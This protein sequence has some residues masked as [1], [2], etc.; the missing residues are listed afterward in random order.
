MSLAAEAVI[1]RKEE[2]RHKGS[3]RS[4]LHNHRVVDVRREARAS[5]L[6]Y[7]FLR[8][9][10]IEQGEQNP[11]RGTNLYLEA[12]KRAKRIAW[13][14]SGRQDDITFDNEFSAWVAKRPKQP[15]FNPVS[16]G[17]NPAPRTNPRVA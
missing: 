1:I 11:D 12:Q 14:F 10:P 5:L 13:K 16:A 4:S 15:A 2:R 6:A 17:S 9:K 7:A 8:G 3:V